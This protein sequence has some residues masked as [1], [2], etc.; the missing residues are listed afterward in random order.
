MADESAQEIARIF[1]EGNKVV[2]VCTGCDRKLLE[3]PI[4]S[5]EQWNLS[6]RRLGYCCTRALDNLGEKYAREG[7]IDV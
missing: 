1:V 6:I 2:V 4:A 3:R 5:R 7:Y